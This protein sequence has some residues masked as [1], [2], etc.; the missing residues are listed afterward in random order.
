MNPTLSAVIKIVNFAET[1]KT[2]IYQILDRGTITSQVEYLRPMNLI[3]ALCWFIINILI[4]ERNR[5][6]VHRSPSVIS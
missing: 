3:S 2:S 6:T 1:S 5:F 4:R